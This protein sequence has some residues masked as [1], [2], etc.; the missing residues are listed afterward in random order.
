VAL[1]EFSVKWIFDDQLYSQICTSL[2]LSLSLSLC[3]FLSQIQIGS[4]AKA[5]GIT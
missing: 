3:H 2:S 4:I 1:N 5:L